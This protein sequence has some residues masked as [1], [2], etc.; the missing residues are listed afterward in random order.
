[1][2]EILKHL[3]KMEKPHKESMT[4]E[5]TSDLFLSTIIAMQL[6]PF[7]RK[8]KQKHLLQHFLIQELKHYRFA[9]AKAI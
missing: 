4:K 1:M 7:K 9:F 6:F 2:P 5:T 8:K 3:D